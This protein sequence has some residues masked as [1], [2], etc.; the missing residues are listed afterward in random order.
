MSASIEVKHEW[1]VTL[2]RATATF[3]WWTLCNKP[4]QKSLVISSTRGGRGRAG[5]TP[6][7][8]RLGFKFAFVED[9]GREAANSGCGGAEGGV[10]VFN[11]GFEGRGVNSSLLCSG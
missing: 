2:P 3:W 9:D 11:K 5:E 4:S 1:R 6:E 8:W 7:A 10:K